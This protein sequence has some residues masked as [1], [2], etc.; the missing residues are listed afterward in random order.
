MTDRKE[1]IK[2]QFFE[3]R[4]PFVRTEFETVDEDGPYK[5]QSWKPG[6]DQILTGPDGESTST[7][8]GEGTMTLTVVDVFKP[9][10]YPTRV[11]FTRS[12]A[13]PTGAAFGKNK[14][15]VAT[16][17]KFRRLARGYA[18]HYRVQTESEIAEAD[19]KRIGID[20]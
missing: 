20:A 19:R 3:V 1:F 2:G 5:V 8:H 18:H 7:A 13:P 9:G 4:Y 15:R 6:V 17:E 14:L 16:A 12:F 10:R 11:F